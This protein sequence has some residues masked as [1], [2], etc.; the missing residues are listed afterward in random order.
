MRMP[1]G[2]TLLRQP[3]VRWGGG[4]LRVLQP[5]LVGQRGLVAQRHLPAQ[6][7]L[8]VAVD[9]DHLNQHLVALG[10]H[11]LDRA[12][13]GLGDLRDV[14]Q[15]LGVGNDLDE[16]AELDDL[17]HLAE[18]DP[19]QLHLAADVL[20]HA[21]CLLHRRAVGRED[22][23][24]PV[25]LDV[26]LGA[27]LFL[28]PAHHLA[29]GADDLADLL[30]ANLDGHEA[31]RERAQLGAGLLDRLAHLGQHGEPRL[32]RLAQRLPHDL[33]GDPGDLDVHLQRGDA[34]LGPGDLE[35]HVAVVV[36]GAHDVGQDG[37]P[38]AFLDE[39]H[40]D[41]GHRRLD[42]HTGVHQRQ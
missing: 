40:G 2:K 34:L 12:D 7:H 8:A 19:L 15:P 10:Q 16:G 41:P 9:L 22:G 38:V 1:L 35:V 4:G 18:V 28:D 3:P 20:D 32:A 42:R 5:L 14:E 31:R 21:D 25:V 39:P 36:L 17:L 29:A 6:P 11:V 27:R 37:H 33:D 24:P 26:D 30:L 13:P 23:D